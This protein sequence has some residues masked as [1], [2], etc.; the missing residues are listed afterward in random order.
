MIV[1]DCSAAMEIAL[2]SK[3]GKAFQSLFLPNEKVVAP[4]LYEL[5]VANAVWKFVHAGL[6]DV[7]EGRELM[8]NALALVDRLIPIEEL[9]DEIYTEGVA[10]DHSIYDMA[11]MVLA[12]R[13]G[14]TLLTHDARLRKCCMKRDVD[15][16]VEV[17]FKPEPKIV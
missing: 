17:E 14:A 12:R 10:L 3:L 6:L 16:V 13:M 1:L 4:S 5:E 8:L 9:I 11:Y 7:G 2:D 15:H